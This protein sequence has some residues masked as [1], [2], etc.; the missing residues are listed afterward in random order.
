MDAAYVIKKPIITEK[1][2]HDT[3]ASKYTFLVDRKATKDD[4]RKAVQHMYGVKV[5]KVATQVRKGGSRRTR[6]GYVD[7]KVTKKAV[8]TLKDGATIELF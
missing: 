7:A 4:I 5:D 8:V 2:T 3:E 1:S 6:F